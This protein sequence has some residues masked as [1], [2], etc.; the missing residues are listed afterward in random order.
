MQLP[1]VP[2]GH[3]T[4]RFNWRSRLWAAGIHLG[5]SAL[6]ATLSG[7]L[8]FALWYPW[9]Y[10]EISSGREL[11]ELVVSVDVALGPLI[12]FAIFNRAKPR[13]E[14]RRDLVVVALLQLAGLAYGL[15]TVHL[16]RP[17]HMVY[18]IDRFR[19]VH[20]VDIPEALADR[21]PAGIP[22]APLGGPT[23]IALRPFRNEQ[24][25][26]DYTLEALRGVSLSARP[27]LWQPYADARER[28]LHAA[29]P[30]ADLQRR[31]P[32]SAAEIAAALRKA[33]RQPAQVAYLPLVARKA[34]AWTVLLDAGTAQVIGYLPLDSF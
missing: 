7:L 15:W 26:V 19:V 27:D 8:V 3:H 23:L 28:V 30:V 6:V 24:E 31:F 4:S 34:M 1:S 10:R 13:T 25:R 11:F 33:G 9:P 21:A 29:K 12:T 20:Q 5:L 17:V 22:V 32:Q 18:E 16:A 2:V 14:L